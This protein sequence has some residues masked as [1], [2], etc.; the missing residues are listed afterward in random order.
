LLNGNL[1][2]MLQEPSLM[3]ALEGAGITVLAKGVNFP[4]SPWVTIGGT[5]PT[6]TPL[7]TDSTSGPNGCGPNTASA[8]NPFPS[9][10]H[11]NPSSIDGLGI[12]NSSQGGGGIFVHAWGHNLEIANNRV[13]NNSGTLSGGIN[14]GQGEFPPSY[15]QGAA[16]ADPGSCQ[17][18]AIPNAQLPYC[19]N[20]HVNVH[21][22][23]ITLNASTGDELF[24]ATPAGAGGI[25]FCTGSDYYKF[26]YNWVCGNLSTGDGGGFGHLGLSFNGDIEHNTILFNQ[27][28]NP[29]IAT[30][31][32]G[33]LI[34]GTPDVDPPC[35]LTTDADCVPANLSTISPSDGAGPGLV[36]NANLIMGNAAES[37]SGGGMRLQ[38]INGSEVVAFPRNPENWYHLTV[39]NNIIANNVAGWDGAGISLI[40]ALNTDIINNTIMSNDTTASSGVLFNTLQ[41]PLASSAGTNCIQAGSGATR[42]C[43]QPAGLV[44]IQTGAVLAANLPAVITCP[45]GHGNGGTGPG[46]LNNGHC[47]RYS[48]PALENNVFWQNRA[49]Y[50]GVGALGAGTLNQQNV[51]ALYNA[52]TTTRGASQP[53]TGACVTGSHFWDIGVR[54]DTSPTNHSGGILTP[55]WSVLTSLGGGYGGENNT[56]SNPTVISQYCNGSRVPPE[57][58]A[59]GYQVPPGISDATVPNP[60][61]NLTPAATV[62]EGNN[63]INIGWGPLTMTNPVNGAQLG[64]YAL[65]PSSPAVDYVFCTTVTGGCQATEEIGHAPTVDFFGNPRP[66]PIVPNRIDVGAIEFQN[67]PTVS[68]S[69]TLTS[70]TPSSG[71]RGR[72][73]PV[74][75]NGANLTAATAVTVTPA[76]GIGVTITS[77]NS[78]TVTANFT[79]AAGAAATARSVT[80]T[81]PVG[82]SNAVTFTVLAP[83]GTLT[84]NPVSFGNQRVGSTST[85]TTVTFTNTTGVPITLRSGTATGLGSANG[86]AVGFT[87]GNT[88]NFAIVAAGTTCTNGAVIA[89]GGTCLINVTFTPNT[90]GLRSSTL[91]IYA[92]G[93]TA[94]FATDAVSGTGIQATVGFSAPSP[95][96][97]TT[98]ANTT[99]KNGTITVTNT[100]TASLTI[101]AT[102]TVTRTAGP[103][104]DVYTVTGGTCAS[105]LVVAA[106]GGTCTIIVHYAPANTTLTTAHVTLTD[107]GAATGTQNSGNFNG[108]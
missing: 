53:I 22:N 79:I 104:T 103:T 9:N 96:F 66:D 99:A 56:S 77:V 27:S 83:S 62:D 61:F 89:T 45:A 88:S 33:I 71:L 51:V 84:P 24:S 46:G 18:S 19:H 58:G 20:V 3:G 82:T 78:N 29:T 80:V 98:P 36:I 65:A 95:V 97:T 37:G 86:P 47:R 87:G 67:T 17:T 107:T 64:N 13:A 54:G 75:L 94:S 92:A 55:R 102:P 11:C 8:K 50:I 2:E 52:F 101:T 57:L 100:G 81:T 49:F 39:T 60:I 72:V 69:P 7:L 26:N 76:A 41:A 35:G 6:G 90:T 93:A 34:M 23:G 48:V 73:V 5:F 40:D 4:S 1:A 106:G 30:N 10:F 32:G 21:N 28:A 68:P 43:P 31:G 108:N 38:H 16:N 12:T 105:G 15:L 42:S 85:P 14:V 59:M 44:S 74:V 91:N 70:I 63:W 25:S